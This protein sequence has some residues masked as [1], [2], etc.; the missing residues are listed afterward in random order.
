MSEAMKEPLA[1]M[2]PPLE[3]YAVSWRCRAMGNVL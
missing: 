3:T 1:M 2:W